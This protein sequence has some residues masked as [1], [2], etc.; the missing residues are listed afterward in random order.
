MNRYNRIILYQERAEAFA[1][2]TDSLLERMSLYS[3][4]DDEVSEFAKALLELGIDSETVYDHMGDFSSTLADEYTLLSDGLYSAVLTGF[5]HLWERDTKDLCKR[6]LHYNPLNEGNK[7]VTERIIHQYKYDKIKE[8]LLFWGAEESMFDEMNLLRLVVNT[9]KHGSGPSATELLGYSSK[10]YNKLTMLC[11][12]EI[13]DFPKQDE[14]PMLGT[15][16]LRYFGTAI[17]TFWTELGKR[18]L[19]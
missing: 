6:V 16:D 5:Y 11:D 18:M 15:D 2:R 7:Q 19:I 17:N 9:I 14:A 3:E 12:L 1:K 4:Y 10:Y 8:L 13:G